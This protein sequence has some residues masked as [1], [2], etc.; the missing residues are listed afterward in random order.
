MTAQAAESRIKTICSN[1]WKIEWKR[2]AIVKFRMNKIGVYYKRCGTID[3]VTDTSED[4]NV[5]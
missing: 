3:G 2:V 1:G 4:S 5:I